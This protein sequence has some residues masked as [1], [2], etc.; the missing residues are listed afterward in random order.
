L[1]SEAV[2]AYGVSHYVIQL[3]STD[4]SLVAAIGNTG[5]E[6]RTSYTYLD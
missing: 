2:N 4:L 1:S 3:M 5:R 6:R